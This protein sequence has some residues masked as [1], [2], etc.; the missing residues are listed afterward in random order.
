MGI[1]MDLENIKKQYLQQNKS[2]NIQEYFRFKEHLEKLNLQNVE[3]YDKPKTLGKDDFLKL[4]I[5]QFSRQDPTNPVKDQEFLAQ[6]AQFSSLEQM[7]NIARSLEQLHT[8]Q[9]FEYL[10]KF[11]SGK[12]EIT[13]KEVSGIVEAIFRDPAGEFYLKVH[14]AAIKKQNVTLIALPQNHVQGDFLKK[15]LSEYE[16][17]TISEK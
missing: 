4:L 12:D 7:Q 1:I 3:I 14:D 9:Y 16:K 2:V 6:M 8:N 13:G 11:V 10:G 15:P 5:T 17:N